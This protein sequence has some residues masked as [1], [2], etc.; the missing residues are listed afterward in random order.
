MQELPTGPRLTFWKMLQLLWH[1]PTLLRL[2]ARLLGDPQVMVGAKALFLGAILFILS[3]LD[4]PNYVPVLGEVSDVVLALLACRW[5]INHC[6]AELVAAH[7][8]AIR[9]RAPVPVDPGPSLK[10]KTG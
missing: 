2:L 6:P 10:E 5:F 8:A 1:L 4:V 7:L 9:G 3:P